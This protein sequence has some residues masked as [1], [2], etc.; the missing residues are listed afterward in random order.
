M[1]ADGQKPDEVSLCRGRLRAAMT[2]LLDS[3]PYADDEPEVP[4]TVNRREQHGDRV[5]P[6]TVAQRRATGE[7][8]ADNVY[9]KRALLDTKSGTAAS[10]GS[11]HPSPH[12]PPPRRA[13]P[14][15]QSNN[16]GNTQSLRLKPSKPPAPQNLSA[17]LT[18]QKKPPEGD[19]EIE[20]APRRGTV[21]NMISRFQHPT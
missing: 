12:P 5:E 18:P 13:V 14:L 6:N 19:E 4:P 21:K 11:S 17:T 7:W 16:I 9:W 10:S 1:S 3:L 15:S 8:A 2:D 20:E